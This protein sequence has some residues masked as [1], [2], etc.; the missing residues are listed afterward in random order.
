VKEDLARLN[1]GSRGFLSLLDNIV[2]TDKACPKVLKFESAG[3][4]RPTIICKKKRAVIRKGR[5]KRMQNMGIEVKVPLGFAIESIKL[6]KS[7]VFPFVAPSKAPVLQ[8][9]LVE[10][11]SVKGGAEAVDTTTVNFSLVFIPASR[12]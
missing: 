5:R 10:L 9:D 3:P 6:A 2:E 7:W 12:V 1:M 8:V 11:T 4:S